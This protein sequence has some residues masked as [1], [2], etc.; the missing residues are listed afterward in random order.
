MLYTHTLDWWKRRQ[1]QGQN[2]DRINLTQKR[3]EKDLFLI[4]QRDSKVTNQKVTF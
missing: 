3:P 1:L 2:Q 4:L